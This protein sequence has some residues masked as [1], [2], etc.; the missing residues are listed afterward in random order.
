MAGFQWKGR[1]QSKYHK[2]GIIDCGLRLNWN[3]EKDKMA[4]MDRFM[5]FLW[6]LRE[7]RIGHPYLKTVG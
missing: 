2:V 7:W 3:E 1:R 5:G 6:P 4:A